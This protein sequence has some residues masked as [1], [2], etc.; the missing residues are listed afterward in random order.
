MPNENLEKI[1]QSVKSA[2]IKLDEIN[3]S[4][5]DKLSKEDLKGLE[6]QVEKLQD[7]TASIENVKF[8]EK[9]IGLTDS[10]KNIQEQVDNIEKETKARLYELGDKGETLDEKIKSLVTGDEW[11]AMAKAA[12]NSSASQSFEIEKA[13]NDLLTSDWT[14]DTG[15][16]GLPQMQIPGVTKHPWK[17]TPIFAS[18]GKRTVGMGHEVSYTEELSRSDAAALK[19]EG[20]QYAQSGA[21]WITKVLSFYDIGHYVK[22]TRESLE[23]AEYIRQEINDLLQMGL[24]AKLESLLYSG[25]GSSTIKGVYTS[26]KTFNRSQGVTAIANPSMRD[27]L[28]AAKLQVA[29]GVNAIAGDSNADSN[30]TGYMANLALLGKSSAYNIVTEKD[31]IGRPL[32]DS[33]DTWR[34]GGMSVAESEYVTETEAQKD[35]VVGAF[36]KAM[37]Y[38]KRNLTIETGY[39]GNDFTYGMTTLRASIRGNLLIKSLEEYGFVKGDFETAPGKLQ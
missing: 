27:V 25:S 29:K 11:K 26:A 23:D 38:L 39:D 2:E 19:A 15:A 10:I 13:A 9:E 17:A 28:M 22:V 1:E 4:L 16:V 8:G 33:I 37:L 12:K 14:A 20:S 30:K 31:D 18:V 32:V 34:P 7:F 3:K 6:S 35:F 21:T 5:A 24:L 36:N